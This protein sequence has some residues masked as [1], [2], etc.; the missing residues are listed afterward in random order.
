MAPPISRTPDRGHHRQLVFMRLDLVQRP[1]SVTNL[2]PETLGEAFLGQFRW[3][4][5][6]VPDEHL[7]G[8]CD[9]VG[10]QELL[11]RFSA[12]W[13]GLNFDEVC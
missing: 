5:V 9:E 3:N 10:V 7:L 2:Q 13:G 12:E 1:R 8:R 6:V 4:F 11:V